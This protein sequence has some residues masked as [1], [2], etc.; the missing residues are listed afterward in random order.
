[1]NQFLAK[2]RHVFL[3][4]LFISVTT[5]LAYSLLHWLIFVRFELIELDDMW[6]NFII[7]GAVVVLVSLIFTRLIIKRLNF[8]SSKSRDPLGG[9]IVVI[10]LSSG[11]A[12]CIALNYIETS[13]GKLTRLEYISAIKKQP[14]TKYYELKQYY[15]DKQAVR[16]HSAFKTSGK[17]DQNFDMTIYCAVPIHNAKVDD[18]VADRSVDSLLLSL[19]NKDNLNLKKALLIVNGREASKA[20]ISRIPRNRIA[21]METIDIQRSTLMYGEK[22]K[23]GVIHFEVKTGSDNQGRSL[24]I[25]QPD[26]WL[27]V[28]Y[29]KTISNDLSPEDKEKEYNRFAEASQTEFDQVDQGT[30]IYLEKVPKSDNLSNFRTAIIQT[31]TTQSADDAIL[32]KPVYEPFEARAGAS[33]GWIFGSFGIG[34]FI[35]LI[36]I[37]FFPLR[38]DHQRKLNSKKSNSGWLNDVK[39]ILWPRPGYSI[40]PVVML[41][42]ISI[43]F[44][45]VIAGLGFLSFRSSDLLTWGAD[46]RPAVIDGDYWRLFTAMFLHGGIM[47]L[48]LN[49]YGLMLIGL[50]LEPVIGSKKFA[51]A[52]TVA[53]LAGSAASLW[54]HPATVGVGASGAIFGMYGVYVALLTTKMYTAAQRKALLTNMAF[55]I[56]INLLMGIKGS[57]DNAA[58]I[59]GLVAGIISGYAIYPFVKRN[60]DAN[61]QETEIMQATEDSAV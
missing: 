47:H 24:I 18:T 15:L 8:N 55:F 36:V 35:F 56:G 37:Q 30:F 1:M 53:G 41:L 23:Y 10:I 26:A 40:S 34:A 17:Y 6:Q 39:G 58:H 43:F 2:L 33:F 16:S 20:E 54:W 45:M 3:P 38:N 52:Y 12:L 32:L 4:Y 27:A 60:T 48:V 9:I 50:L 42:N 7:P 13:T 29:K 25:E 22:G 59:G 46:Y 31:D 49:M 19:Q 61:E 57:V 21:S 5:I 14:L 28:T 44:A 51:I 11:A